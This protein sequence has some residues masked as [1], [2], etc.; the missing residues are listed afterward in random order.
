[1]RQQVRLFLAAIFGLSTL[2][3]VGQ[4]YD[5]LYFT[6]KDRKEK[7]A[8][9]KVVSKA[10]EEKELSFLGRQYQ[11][12][13]LTEEELEQSNPQDYY[14]PEKTQDYYLSQNNNYGGDS[15]N[16]N[17]SQP[18]SD[19][20]GFA[21]SQLYDN[22]TPVVINNYYNDPWASGVNN[23]NRPRWN[24]GLGFN[25]WGGSFWS[26]SYGNGWYD[27]FWDPWWGW[28]SWGPRWGWNV[29]WGW[30]A[31]W[32]WGGGWYDPWWGP[33]YRRPVY[34]VS[35]YN[36]RN[37]VRSG[38]ATRGSSDARVSRSSSGRGASSTAS[39]SRG[40]DS[41]ASNYNRQQ[42]A[43]LN[44]A[45]SSRYN[46]GVNN[47]N[48]STRGRGVSTTQSGVVSSGNGRSATN[49]NFN[50]AFNNARTPS[51]RTFTPPS[52]TRGRG[53]SVG[54]PSRS[55]RSSSGGVRSSGSSSRSSGRSSSRSSGR[56]SSGRR[57]N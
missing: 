1:M 19:Q 21:D 43:Y 5:D 17:F 29:G 42:A 11:Y 36:R 25:T 52:S 41:R 14:A 53:S 40:E 28:N 49:N 12:A 47:S 15:A 30:N 51:G 33:A 57:G 4:E 23:W 44:Q 8:K 32:G 3:V 31:G 10:E 2:W 48:V 7:Q 22:N 18:M 45:R 27:P 24:V 16:P 46:P 26:L 50:R 9:E 55:S 20:Q 6:K 54:T 34:V 39:V 13:P 35:D 56:S 37:V 38:R